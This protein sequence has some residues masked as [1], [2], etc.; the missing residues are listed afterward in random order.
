MKRFPRYCFLLLLL[1]IVY[2]HPG[3]G[4]VSNSKGVIYYTDLEHVWKIKPNGQKS[5][6]VKNVHTHE[7]Y[8]DKDDNLFGVH[9]WYE[10]EE[11]DKWGHY[12]WKLGADGKFEKIIPNSEG[13]L[14]DYSFVRDKAG[15]MNFTSETDRTKLFQVN[16]Q[17]EKS[18][19][20]DGFKNIRWMN[21]T[22]DGIIYIV[23]LLSLKRIGKDGTV[24]TVMEKVTDKK[25]FQFNLRE[26]HAVMGVWFD[27]T[28]SV[29]VAAFAEGKI[30][31]VNENGS[32]T[33]IYQSKKGWGPTGGIF[34]QNG[35]L[36][37]LEYSNTNKVRVVKGELTLRRM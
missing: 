4:I 29:Y 34:D 21:A 33:V 10:G 35:D 12:V 24:S 6:A 28:N 27:A 5:I 11:I 30:L 9:V 2:S 18:L 22:D 25:W 37:V 17:G 26:I 15:N 13:F 31:K 14:A 32:T 23:D 20:A 7:L 1:S 19:L 8:L 36:W 16:S 3:I